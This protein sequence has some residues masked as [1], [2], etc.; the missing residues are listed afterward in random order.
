[1][2]RHGCWDDYRVEREEKNERGGDVGETVV[3][4]RR[5]RR[6]D[7]WGGE[8]GRKRDQKR[9]KNGM[10][11][12]NTEKIKLSVLQQKIWGKI[13][14]VAVVVV[15]FVVVRVTLLKHLFIH[16][17]AVVSTWPG[18]DITDLV[19]VPVRSWLNRLVVAHLQMEDISWCSGSNTVVP[20][21]LRENSSWHQGSWN[22]CYYHEYYYWKNRL[23]L[24]F[25]H[26]SNHCNFFI[27]FLF[28]T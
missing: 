10:I 17:D 26:G 12:N 7:E 1:M 11:A 27:V 3:K 9:E 24:R 4:H 25:E 14:S 13:S 6:A 23:V 18:P 16:K 21:S 28:Y 5:N 22:N 19:W 8:N 20:A 2:S 15:V